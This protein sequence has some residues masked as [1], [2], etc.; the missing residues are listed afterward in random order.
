MN[1]CEVLSEGT[2]RK[3]KGSFKAHPL[4]H[5]ARFQSTNDTF[6]TAVILMSFRFLEKLEQKVVRLQEELVTRE[7]LYEEWL[8]CGRTELQDALPISLGQ[9]FSAWAGPVERDRW[10]INKL[11]ERLRTHPWA[12]RLSARVTR[13]PQLCFCGGK[14]AQKDYRTSPLPEPEYVRSGSPYG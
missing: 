2:N 11:K 3:Y 7:S 5:L 8:M 4:D 13:L 6:P 12:E 10:R 9:L 1:I 14:R